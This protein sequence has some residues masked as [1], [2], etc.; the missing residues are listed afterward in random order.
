MHA[1]LIPA[2]GV[3][4]DLCV[5]KVRL[6]YK[7]SSWATEKPCLKH[8]HTHTHTHTHTQRERERERERERD[9]TIG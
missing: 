8:I 4:V 5:F 9:T 2:L 1:P 3:Q 6:V 7:A